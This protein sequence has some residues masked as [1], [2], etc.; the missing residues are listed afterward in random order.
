MT[1]VRRVSAPVLT[2]W[3]RSLQVRAVVIT[4]VSTSVAILV[5]SAVATYSIS[6]D[7]FQSRLEQVLSVSNRAVSESQ[8]SLSSSAATDTASI[9]ELMN[10]VLSDI[11]ATTTSQQV[12]LLRGPRASFGYTQDITSG[13]LEVDQ[14]PSSLRTAVEETPDGLWWQS[15]E[16]DGSPAIVVGAGLTV[17]VAGQHEVYV[18][19]D[20]SS[21]AN[22]LAFVQQ[23]LY[24][25]GIALAV[26]LCGITL[27]VVTSIVRPVRTTALTSRRLA[28]GDLAQRVDVRGED[29]LAMLGDS[30]NKMAESIQSQIIQL[31][32]L[33]TM[34]Q[35]F[36]SD[37]SHEL[38]TPL[39][40]IRLASDMIFGAREQLD[41]GARRAAELLHDQ[42]D[43]FEVLLADLLE[44]SRFD[45]G[46]AVLEPTKFELKSV[47]SQVVGSFLALAEERG[48][49]I[50]V[51]GPRAK[52]FVLA[53]ERRIER[54]VRNL[55]ANA[56][57]HGEGR[58]I[59]V[60]VG[61][62][63]S[64]V[65]VAV[66]DYGVG[67]S[68]EDKA[69]VFDRFWRADSSRKRTIGGTGLGLSIAMEDT[70]LHHGR[71][72]VWSEPG[73]GACFRLMIPRTPDTPLG[74]S[75]L[76]LPPGQGGPQTVSI[77]VIRATQEDRDEGV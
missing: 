55:L 54:I 73:Q 39:T 11:E 13:G 76:G 75:P 10:K 44:V 9:Q 59:D 56:I 37:V 18:V 62:S 25:G 61:A 51:R 67:I 35:R 69:R 16:V 43:R 15:T 40:T 17:Q 6:Q 52:C 63:R 71:L 30:F 53:D 1:W 60:W 72:D 41:V 19:F 12:A 48:S 68:G 3:R 32:T 58:P 29:E 2:L 21:E 50:T 33:S 24:V 14:L 23:I 8:D 46:A 65:A 38:R 74:G 34:Q 36:V 26:L 7:L 28:D 4:L 70:G 47:V 42:V 20:L 5:Y 27:A 57:E 64:T 45:A 77:K 22:T 66:R 49:T 31:K